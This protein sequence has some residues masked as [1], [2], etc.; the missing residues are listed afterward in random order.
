M[1]LIIA[2]LFC[3]L[4]A[5][6]ANYLIAFAMYAKLFGMSAQDIPAMFM[7]FNPLVKNTPGMLVFSMIPFNLIK[8]GLDPIP[9]YFVFRNA[10]RRFTA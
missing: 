4:T 6:F 10:A 5:V 7:Q 9:S 3:S 2:T 8:C 1:A